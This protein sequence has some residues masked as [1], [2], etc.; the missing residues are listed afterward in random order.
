[1]K[2]SRNYSDSDSDKV[3]TAIIELSEPRRA[4]EAA[5]HIVIVKFFKRI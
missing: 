5:S 2:K 1:M 3:Y 4:I